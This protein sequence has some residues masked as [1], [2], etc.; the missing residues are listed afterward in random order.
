MAS[1]FTPNVQLEEPARGDDVGTWDTPVNANTTNID[2]IVGAIATI[3]LNN[4]N[5]VLSAAQFRSKQITFV[6]TLTGSVTITFPTSFTKSYEIQ[7]LCTGSSAFTVTLKTTSGGQG[8]CCPPGETID[9]FNDGANLKFKNF[10]RVG[11]YWDYAGS[12]VPNWI[13]GCSLPPYLVCDGSG[14]SGTNYPALAAI[15]NGLTLPDQRGRTRYM[16]DQGAG[17]VSS[18]VSNVAGNSLF[19]GGGDQ[20]MQQHTH[21]VSDPGHAHTQNGTTLYLNGGAQI[22]G[23]GGANMGTNPQNTATNTTGITLVNTGAG[24]AQN[25]PPLLVSGITLIRSA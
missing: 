12:S 8:I 7:H 1:T 20:S 17:R 5:V 19:T 4:T 22:Y 24:A 16:L 6:S 25:M 2:L 23:A 15:L 11:T 18:G 14:F 13:A 21:G 10:G 9:C 3:S